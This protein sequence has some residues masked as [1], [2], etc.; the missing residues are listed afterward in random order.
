VS[1]KA[2]AIAG[3]A[4]VSFASGVAGQY[5]YPGQEMSPVDL[6]VLPAFAF[7]I[8]WWYRTDS[9]QLGY[10]RTPWLN[11]GVIAAAALALPYYFFRTRGFK[12]GSLATLGLFGAVVASGLLTLGGQY[13]AYLGLQS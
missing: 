9:S 6:W 4:L 13:A 5:F 1:P 10:K 2:Y 7:F 12:R 8:F 3:L 11:V